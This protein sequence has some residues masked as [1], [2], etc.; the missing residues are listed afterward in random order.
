MA[1]FPSRNDRH[2][3]GAWEEVLARFARAAGIEVSESRPIRLG[4]PHQCS[5][6]DVSIAQARHVGHMRRP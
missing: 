1:K 3:V 4:G 2:D 5:H 6:P